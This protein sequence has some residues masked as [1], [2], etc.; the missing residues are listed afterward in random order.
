MSLNIVLLKIQK[1][2]M[3]DSMM[4]MMVKTKSIFDFY[5][6]CPDPDH[7]EIEEFLMDANMDREEFVH[8][9]F[10]IFSAFAS[11]GKFNESGL[12]ID[13]IDHD[14]LMKGMRVEMEH[15]KCPLMARRIALD[16]LSEIHDYYDK[17]EI[18]ENSHL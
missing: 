11:H 6:K 9:V 12:T 13:D 3:N 7:H 1:P 14:Q 10:R 4:D 5:S 16:H 18:M 17:L 8:H 2:N 15:T